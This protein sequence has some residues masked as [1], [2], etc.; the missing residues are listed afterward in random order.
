MGRDC[1]SDLEAR[2]IDRDPGWRGWRFLAW[3]MGLV[4]EMM[5]RKVSGELR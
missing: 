4:G 3:L 2:R 1:V 5:K